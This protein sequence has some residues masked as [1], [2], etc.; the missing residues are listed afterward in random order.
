MEI[1]TGRLLWRTCDTRAI[2]WHMSEAIA[3]RV[4]TLTLG[5][6]LRIALDP[7][8]SLEMAR[9]LGVHRATLTRWMSD[10]GAPPRAA[11]VRQWALITGVDYGWLSTGVAPSGDGP[12]QKR[13]A[14]TWTH[15]KSPLTVT[16]NLADV[17]HL[18]LDLAQ[19]AA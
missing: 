8:S 12:S 18:P 5:W 15:G 9:L 7:M 4:P 2:M 17:T 6:R 13:A 3:G 10:V 11:Y 16:G 14:M 1:S 19:Q